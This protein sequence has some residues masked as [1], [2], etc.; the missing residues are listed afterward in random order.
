MKWHG[1]TS[2]LG[3]S[4]RLESLHWSKVFSSTLVQHS[5]HQAYFLSRKG[6]CQVHQVVDDAEQLLSFPDVASRF[7]LGHH[8]SSLWREIQRMLADFLPVPPLNE[9]SRFS[10]WKLADSKLDCISTANVYALLKS[11]VWIVHGNQLWCLS[12]SPLWWK[13]TL[14]DIWQN[15]LPLKERLFLW[16]CLVGVLPVG[17]LLHACHIAP[18]RCFRCHDGEETLPHLLWGCRCSQSSFQQVSA[19]LRLRFPSATFHRSFF[20]QKHLWEDARTDLEAKVQELE[21]KLAKKE[22]PIEIDIES[23]KLTKCNERLDTC[24]NYVLSDSN[25]ISTKENSQMVLGSRKT[26]TTTLKLTRV[27]PVRKDSQTSDVFAELEENI[28]TQ[29]DNLSQ[30]MNRLEH[31]NSLDVGS[32]LKRL[33]RPGSNKRTSAREDIQTEQ[34]LLEPPNLIFRPVK[35]SIV[36]IYKDRA[37]SEECNLLEHV[38]QSNSEGQWASAGSPV[39]G[40]QLPQTKQ[41]EVGSQG[42]DLAN[43]IDMQQQDKKFDGQLSERPDMVSEKQPTLQIVS[44]WAHSKL[45]GSETGREESH[46]SRF[47]EQDE[48]ESTSNLCSM[49]LESSKQSG[50]ETLSRLDRPEAEQENSLSTEA[51]D[52]HLKEPLAA[53]LKLLVSQEQLKEPTIIEKSFEHAVDKHQ[54]DETHQVSVL[55]VTSMPEQGSKALTSEMDTH[56]E[57]ETHC[58]SLSFGAST[59]EQ[60]SK[61]LTSDDNAVLEKQHAKEYLVK[62]LDSKNQIKEPKEC[63]SHNGTVLPISYSAPSS[64]DHAQGEESTLDVAYK[65]QPEMEDICNDCSVGSASEAQMRCSPVPK[66]ERKK[67]AFVQSPANE[68]LCNMPPYGYMVNCKTCETRFHA[69]CVEIEKILPG[70]SYTCK[71]CKDQPNRKRRQ[72]EFGMENTKER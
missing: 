29:P 67:K 60:G 18:S 59:L 72:S 30:H 26:S 9:D 54:E 57:D 16:C 49:L 63:H 4:L 20:V 28:S 66:T 55:S 56:Q 64:K 33:G 41:Y 8:Y 71:N 62:M 40:E 36:H 52:Q 38:V 1:R 10:D 27:E 65:A 47:V 5:P 45:N 34:M 15:H 43:E 53:Q 14:A 46:I 21:T 13:R 51:D 7:C 3:N 2:I 58:S 17:I 48:N 23:E 39:K 25:D 22:L 12:K 35:D 44:L 6:I 24:K 42:D 19:A 50:M 37:P 31:G 32:I 70:E 11:D 69:A 61:V 68:C